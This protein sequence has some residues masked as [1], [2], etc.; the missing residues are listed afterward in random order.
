MGAVKGR[1][2][3]LRGLRVNI[4]TN[5]D[6]IKA[7][8]WVNVA[9]ILHNLIIDVE[10]AEAGA[11]FSD[12]HGRPEEE[13]DRGDRDIPLGENAEDAGEQKRIRLTAEL[14]VTRGM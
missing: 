1:W 10:G 13:E 3:A 8:H 6:H 2:Q 5:E 7:I 4:N 9:M 12:E 11:A 14:M